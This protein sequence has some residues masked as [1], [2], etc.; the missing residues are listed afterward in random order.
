MSWSWGTAAPFIWVG[1]GQDAFPMFIYIACPPSKGTGVSNASSKWWQREA[2]KQAK[3]WAWMKMG[4]AHWE[5]LPFP[6]APK[7]GHCSQE[8]NCSLGI[9]APVQNLHHWHRVER[10]FIEGRIAV[11]CSESDW[12]T[13]WTQLHYASMWPWLGK[14]LSLYASLLDGTDNTRI[15]TSQG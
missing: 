8:S 15:S 3:R 6:S 10:E 1:S 5:A 13:F 12:D 2:W 4:L 11:S 14:P 7:G 9:G